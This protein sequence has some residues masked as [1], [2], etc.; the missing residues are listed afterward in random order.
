MLKGNLGKF[1]IIIRDFSISLSKTD[2]TN[3]QK[4]S[5]HVEEL[6][7]IINQDLID[8][9]RALYPTMV[10]NTFFKCPWNIS[11]AKDRPYLKPLIEAQQI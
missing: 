11:S 1:T 3:R 9:Y 8:I 6:N 5:K 4:V 7:N 10:E 2:G